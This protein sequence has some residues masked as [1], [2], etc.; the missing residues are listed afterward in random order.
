MSEP[1]SSGMEQALIFANIA[2]LTLISYDTVLTASDEF[3]L[4][5]QGRFRVASALTILT[6]Y[7]SFA[8]FILQLYTMINENAQSNTECNTVI[9][10]SSQGAAVLLSV[11]VHGL[12][13]GRAY[14]V[15]QR[16]RWM[17]AIICILSVVYFGV[18]CTTLLYAPCASTAPWFLCRVLPSFTVTFDTII[19]AITG[20]QIWKSVRSVRRCVHRPIALLPAILLRQSILLLTLL[21]AWNVE[22]IIAQGLNISA[23]ID[24]SNLLFTYNKPLPSAIY[25]GVTVVIVCRF[26]L[27]LRKQQT[28]SQDEILPS[29]LFAGKKPRFSS[30]IRRMDYTLITE[31]GGQEDAEPLQMDII[32]CTRSSI[33]LF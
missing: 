6:R 21:L 15:C 9:M 18:L 5:W 8:S 27:Q 7:S 26:I 11:G 22:H 30:V 19:L 3:L 1:N 14:A 28:Q 24:P 13:A 25:L 31:F 12:L 33:C 32:E 17:K 29:S 16:D 10:L 2:A 20:Y 23:S 4:I